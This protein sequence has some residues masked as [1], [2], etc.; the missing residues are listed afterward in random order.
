MVFI[1]FDLK[2]VPSRPIIVNA[3]I[4]PEYTL[5]KWLVA[6]NGGLEIRK[7]FLEWSPNFYSE[8]S[9][10]T[11]RDTNAALSPRVV[12]LTI[13]EL[14]NG[15]LAR[16]LSIPENSQIRIYVENENGPSEKS[17][18]VRLVCLKD[19]CKLIKIIF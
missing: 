11:R 7:G 12:P 1:L 4:L 18:P 5:I 14:R 15:Q 19:T 17:V 9:T 16:K 3:S 13:E 2:D 8:E 10:R 6:N